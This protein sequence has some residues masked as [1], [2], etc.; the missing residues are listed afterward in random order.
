[1]LAAGVSACK[2]PFATREAEPPVA[3]RSRWIPPSQPQ[4]VLENLRNAVVEEHL[5][6][7][8]KCLSDSLTTGREFTF[9]AEP[10][11]VANYPD[12]F[13]AW[14]VDHERRYLDQLFQA[15]PRDSL[16][17]L[18]F[19]NLTEQLGEG[20]ERM[21]VGDYTLEVHHTLVAEGI[22]RRVRGRAEFWLIQEPRTSY[23]Y[24]WRWRDSA[25]SDEPTWSAIKA[26]FGR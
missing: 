7:Y 2:N 16:R 6:N 25:T 5:L 13:A 23:W 26:A 17:S 22:P 14:D 12:L 3:S 4:D 18:R 21:L 24:I 9:E 19:S 10:S 8:L 20:N 11:V 1:M 15:T